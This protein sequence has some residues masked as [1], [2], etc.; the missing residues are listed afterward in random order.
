MQ[1]SSSFLPPHL[2]RLHPL[3]SADVRLFCAHLTGPG[4]ARA[5]AAASSSS[6]PLLASSSTPAPTP[7]PSPALV[8]SDPELRDSHFLY[9]RHPLSGVEVAGVV[10][11][12]DT[13][14]GRVSC[15]VDDGTGS[16]QVVIF[17]RH[18]DGGQTEHPAVAAGDPVIVAGTLSW[19]H[20]M[21]SIGQ[22]TREILAHRVRVVRDWGELPRRWEGTL[23]LHLTTYSL[24]LEALMPFGAPLD[25][26]GGGTRGDEAPQ[27][28]RRGGPGAAAAAAAEEEDADDGGGGSPLS[29][30]VAPAHRPEPALRPQPR[31]PF[32]PP[33]GR[34][35]GRAAA[36]AVS[37]AAS[38]LGGLPAPPTPSDVYSQLV[39]LVERIVRGSH[40][41]AVADRIRQEARRVEAKAQARERFVRD[42]LVG[43]A[44]GGVATAAAAAAV[45]GAAASSSREGPAEQE[46]KAAAGG[47]G[48]V[49]GDD[50]DVEEGDDDD[51]SDGDAGEK[52]DDEAD[53]E[54]EEGAGGGDGDGPRR[55]KGPHE[56]TAG[57]FSRL[58][59][60]PVPHA[61]GA[62]GVATLDEEEDTDGDAGGGDVDDDDDDAATMVDER[63]S[64]IVQRSEGFASEAVR[65]ASGPR[66]VVLRP[67]GTGPHQPHSHLSSS[68]SSSS[69]GGGLPTVTPSKIGQALQSGAWLIAETLASPVEGLEG[70][71]SGAS[72]VGGDDGAPPPSTTGAAR[73]AQ[74]AA[75]GAS[76]APTVELPVL[77]DASHVS[78]A[79]VRLSPSFASSA[80]AVLGGGGRAPRPA[81]AA[82]AADS[83][84]SLAQLLVP[85][86]ADALVQLC[87]DGLLHV[88]PFDS[89]SAAAAAAMVIV[90]TTTTTT[91]GGEWD[92]GGAR[93]S[94]P[95]P[96]YGLVTHEYLVRPAMRAVLAEV[97]GAWAAEMVRYGEASAAATAAVAAR[98]A[99]GR[100]RGGGGGGSSGGEV[101][102][103]AAAAADPDLDVG[104]PDPPPDAAISHAEL[105]RRTREAC[106]ELRG[107]P[108]AVLGRSVPLL[109]A[110]GLLIITAPYIY[111]P[112][113]VVEDGE[114]AAE[115]GGEGTGS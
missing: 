100:G 47:E 65:D 81:V 99:G 25:L 60:I 77:F 78:A 88:A 28:A 90:R 76:P 112:G 82:S 13:K 21:L 7:A 39:A 95:L 36:A 68:S 69:A 52:D 2:W 107:V 96:V 108:A 38:S 62:G 84:Q 98:A 20:R 5:P 79:L 93:T 67:A 64:H 14:E 33:A 101:V 45:S 110:E 8:V 32:Q 94:S 83:A 109:Q 1:L 58:L 49:D 50:V 70:G 72:G 37:G 63:P 11:A 87:K 3:Y 4:Q 12:V 18:W 104:F 86:V 40:P 31:R 106:A 43:A 89:S 17:T 27:A 105:L 74:P 73:A 51:G 85:H 41:H 6:D 59:D 9:G 57:H 19:G 102:A 114:G 53:E 24:P 15:L 54:D 30:P 91:E 97:H 111:A 23:R 34:K 29:P 66:A 26:G 16:A 22:T 103:A 55:R 44:A 46:G 42:R 80:A 56:S 48:G 115:M 71:L 61:G 35:R 113:L 92:V 75:A 10:T